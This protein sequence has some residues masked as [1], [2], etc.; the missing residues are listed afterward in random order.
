MNIYGP[1]AE[2]AFARLPM[3]LMENNGV[4]THVATHAPLSRK[5]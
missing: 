4:R 2:E 5:R 3:N 1:T